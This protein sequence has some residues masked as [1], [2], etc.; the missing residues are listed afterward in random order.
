[1]SAKIHKSLGSC[2]TRNKELWN[3]RIVE[4]AKLNLNGTLPYAGSTMY[5]HYSPCSKNTVAKVEQQ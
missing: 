4:V 1:M 3:N 5:L 2:K